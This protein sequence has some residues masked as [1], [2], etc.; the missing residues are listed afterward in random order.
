MLA[1]RRSLSLALIILSGGASG[2]YADGYFDQGRVYFEKKQYAKALPYFHKA[3]AD[4]PWDST[5]AYYEALCYHNTGDW[6]HAKDAY[7]SIVQHFPGTPASQ[8]AMGALKILDPRYLQEYSKKQTEV[9]AAPATPTAA[10]TVDVA[11]L[12]AKV[13]VTAP[14]EN[15]IPVTRV[16][17]K[18]W[19]DGSVNGRGFKFDFSGDSTTISTKDAKSMNLTVNSGH[20]IVTVK[21]GQISEYSF[22]LAVED[23]QA[24]KLGTDFFQKFAYTLEPS[25]IVATKKSGASTQASSWDIPFAKKGKDIVISL[26]VN[27]RNVSAILDPDGSENVVPRN[28]CREFGLDAVD[29]SSVDRYDPVM[30]PSGPLRGQAGWGEVK[31]IT[32]AEAKIV[33][34]PASS[35]VRF[36]IDDHATDAKVT[37][38]IF[39][40][41]KYQLDPAANKIHFTR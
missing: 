21:V 37:P 32:A 28:R 20:A 30:N 33:V 27:G 36:K 8:N 17:D 11:A 40:S 16:T 6:A 41:W 12:L 35:Q 18:T 38:G 3:C 14:N 10:P 34:G 23:T 29:S 19:V 9:T 7:K 31:E 13:Q 24:P 39:G 5:S 15:K 2:V 4:S 22:P 1:F 26:Q 25:N